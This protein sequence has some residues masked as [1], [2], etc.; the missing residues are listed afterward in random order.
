MS[1]FRI[2]ATKDFTVMSNAHFRD[3][4][5]SL[6]AKGLLSQMLSLPAEW[7]YTVKGLCSINKENESAIQSAL[8]ELEQT[9][10]LVRTRRQDERGRFDC[11]YDIYEQ[12]QDKKTVGG[13]S[14]TEN[15]ATENPAT[16]DPWPE[17]HPTNIIYNNKIR[18]N[19]IRNKQ[20]SQPAKPVATCAPEAITLA[21]KLNERIL[22]NKPNRKIKSNWLENWSKDI[23]K[24]HRIDGRSWEEIEKVIDWSQ[25]D[26]FWRTNILSGEKLRKK[27]DTLEDQMARENKRA[28]QNI[29]LNDY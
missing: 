7:D 6:K 26:P 17:N 24:L 13:K 4:R 2:N 3:K 12:P 20:M 27:I 25:N 28:P 19:K 11:I 23:D 9:G 16:E 10:Y 1:V 5:L 14:V 8:H 15:P 22:E 21:K 18:N 29:N